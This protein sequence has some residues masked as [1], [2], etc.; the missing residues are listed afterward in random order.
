MIVVVRGISTKS[1]L[2]RDV[3]C[4]TFI[5]EEYLSTLAIEFNLVVG[6]T[7]LRDV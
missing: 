4:Q 1:L 7:F 3:G 5:K 6:E 2:T